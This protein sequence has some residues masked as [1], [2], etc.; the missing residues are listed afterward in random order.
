MKRSPQWCDVM[1]CDEPF[2]AGNRLNWATVPPSTQ[3]QALAT[4]HPSLVQ[5]TLFYWLRIHAIIAGLQYGKMSSALVTSAT[6]GVQTCD[7]CPQSSAVLGTC[8]YREE[9]GAGHLI[10]LIHITHVVTSSDHCDEAYHSSSPDT[11]LIFYVNESGVCR[12]C[13]DSV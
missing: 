3:C 5:A 6:W 2:E 10:V 1:W 4:P 11:D 7:K 8:M 12:Y 13:L 9:P